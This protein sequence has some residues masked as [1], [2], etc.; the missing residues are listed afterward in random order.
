MNIYV[1]R[2]LGASASV[3][4][5]MRGVREAALSASSRGGKADETEQDALGLKERKRECGLYVRLFVL[6]RFV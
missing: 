2:G 5:W 1:I 3:Y 4:I 6:M